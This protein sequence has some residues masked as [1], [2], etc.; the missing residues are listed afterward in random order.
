MAR[1]KQELTFADISRIPFQCPSR[2]TFRKAAFHFAENLLLFWIIPAQNFKETH[3][4]TRK[5]EGFLNNIWLM[6][7][8][9]IPVIVPGVTGAWLLSDNILKQ[10]DLFE[11]LKFYTDIRI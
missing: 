7:L 6:V 1:S 9:F 11:Q 5:V 10:V 8:P 3:R 2:V 4:G